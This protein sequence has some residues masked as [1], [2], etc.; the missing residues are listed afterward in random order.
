MFHRVSDLS[1]HDLI[2]D[3]GYILAAIELLKQILS[4]SEPVYDFIIF[5]E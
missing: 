1:I 4:L 5:C 2:D 3:S